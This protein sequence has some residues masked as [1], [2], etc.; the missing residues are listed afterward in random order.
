[1]FIFPFLIR[2]WI[3]EEKWK[4]LLESYGP[5]LV[6]YVIVMVILF[7]YGQRGLTWARLRGPVWEKETTPIT[8]DAETDAA[9]RRRVAENRPLIAAAVKRGD[10]EFLYRLA[11]EYHEEWY[12]NEATALLQKAAELDSAGPWGAEARAKLKEWAQP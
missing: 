10:A 12:L 4:S 1:M 5:L 7:F 6:L 9:R 11:L 3:D 2:I 8:Y